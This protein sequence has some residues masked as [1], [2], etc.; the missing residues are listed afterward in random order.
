[1]LLQYGD[2]LDC[3][4]SLINLLDERSDVNPPMNVVSTFNR[5]R[6]ARRLKQVG[7]SVELE[8]L[9]NEYTGDKK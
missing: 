3:I 6:F 9:L 5:H 4:H 1:M 7:Q 8:A 2:D